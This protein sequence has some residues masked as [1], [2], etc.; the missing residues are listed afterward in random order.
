MV[1]LYGVTTEDTN[2]VEVKKDEEKKEENF[3]ERKGK[4]TTNVDLSK[5]DKGKSVKLWLPI[6]QDSEYQKITN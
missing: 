2:K 6:P 5:Y 1:Q 4:L 3:A